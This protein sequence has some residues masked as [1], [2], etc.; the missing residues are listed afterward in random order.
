MDRIHNLLNGVQESLSS[1]KTYDGKKRSDLKDND[2]LFPETRSF[3]IVS[4]TDVQDAVHNYGRM[5]GH[6]TYDAFL[7]KLYNFCKNKGPEFVAALPDASKEKLGLKKSKSEHLIHMDQFSV[8]DYVKNIN[9][10]CMHYGSEG[11]V[12]DIES[13]PRNM[14]KI[15]VYKTTNSGAKWNTVN[16]C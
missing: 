2:F 5:S 9:S 12:E 13:L 11:V 3:P 7:H 8:G 10:S 15:V 14:G 6:M 4:P 16:S 1:Q